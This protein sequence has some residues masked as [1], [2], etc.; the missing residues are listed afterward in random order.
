MDRQ[1]SKLRN[2]SLL[3]VVSLRNTFRRKWRLLLTL[4]TLTLGGAVFI[5]T[6]NVRVSMMDYISQIIQ[7]FEADVELHSPWIA[8]TY[9]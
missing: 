2:F 8:P 5:A 6:F 1:L 7:Y 4:V 9:R 3:L